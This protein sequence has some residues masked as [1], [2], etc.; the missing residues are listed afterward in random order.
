[1]K[2][3]SSM[4]DKVVVFFM[5]VTAL[6]GSVFL[7]FV[8]S[9]YYRFATKIFDFL[10]F[11]P[12]IVLLGFVTSICGIF[13]LFSN[14]ILLPIIITSLTI[15]FGTQFTL[16]WRWFSSYRLKNYSKFLQRL[17]NNSNIRIIA[18]N[19]WLNNPQKDPD[20]VLVLIRHDVDISLIRAKRMSIEEKKLNIPSCY[21]LRNNAERYSFDEAKQFIQYL[22]ESSLFSVGFHYESITKV[23]GDLTKATEIFSE[24]VKEFRTIYPIRMVAAHGDK[25]RNGR[26]VSERL[27]DLESLKLKSSY[28]LPYNHYLSEAGGFH[29]FK[30]RNNKKE[31]FLEKLKVLDEITIGSLV[32]ILVHPDWWF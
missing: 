15:Y 1:M 5:V 25:Y 3:T 30:S 11:Y 8:Y 4:L 12:I 21:Y 24:E 32:Q 20:H 9:R 23:K 28:Q 13:Y 22:T 2:V 10:P 14:N 26:L 19:E 31:T 27:V 16:F 17:K 29:H 6:A 18:V 7:W